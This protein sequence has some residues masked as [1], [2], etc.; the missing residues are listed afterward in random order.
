M[1]QRTGRNKELRGT[2][3]IARPRAPRVGLDV[4]NMAEQVVASLDGWDGVMK[5]LPT[6]A[7][8]EYWVMSSNGEPLA[9]ISITPRLGPLIRLT[10]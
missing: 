3:P 6:L 10:K 5:L 8:G 7:L 9:M 2:L 1:P 4:L